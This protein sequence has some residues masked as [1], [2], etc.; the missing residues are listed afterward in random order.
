MKNKAKRSEYYTREEVA[1]DFE[2]LRNNA[3]LYNG[4][5]SVIA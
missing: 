2:L 3:E 1:S 4:T 5:A